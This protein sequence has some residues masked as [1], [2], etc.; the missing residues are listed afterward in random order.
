MGWQQQR[1]TAFVG[2]IDG[3]DKMK[4]FITNSGDKDYELLYITGNALRIKAFPDRLRQLI[5][6]SALF[7][8]RF[9]HDHQRTE[10]IAGKFY[11][12]LL[13]RVFKE[14]AVVLIAQKVG[15]KNG[16]IHFSLFFIKLSESGTEQTMLVNDRPRFLWIVDDR[17]SQLVDW[18]EF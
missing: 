14:A 18:P 15:E 5:R 17:K 10:S 12:I 9:T 8:A 6:E 13:Y 1:I 2:S 4:E 11:L 3:G 7:R 16:R